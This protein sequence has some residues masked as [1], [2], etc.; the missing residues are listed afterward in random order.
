MRGLFIKIFSISMI[1]I[2]M[3][4]V[5]IM[6]IQNYRAD[7]ITNIIVPV[8]FNDPVTTR[9]AAIILLSYVLGGFTGVIYVMKVNAECDQA[10]DYYKRKIQ[11][12]SSNTDADSSLIDS[13]QRKISSLEIA[14]ENALKDKNN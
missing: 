5:L 8:F 2:I 9:V 6:A 4:F 12:I 11:Q 7:F 1:V 14:L 3:L 13:L 10:I